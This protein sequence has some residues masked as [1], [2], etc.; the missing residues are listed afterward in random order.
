MKRSVLRFL[1]ALLLFSGFFL[2]LFA[3]NQ[4]AA[5]AELLAQLHP[6]AP[7][8]LYLLAALLF[9]GLT[10]SAYQLFS[11]PKRPPLPQS[12]S[13]PEMAAWS[14]YMA[15]RLPAHPMHPDASGAVRDQR[16]VK[17]DLKFLEVDALNATKQMATKNFFVGAFAQS[18]S[19]G[20]TTTLANILRLLR[21][22]YDR[23]H[24]SRHPA[25]LAR[26][27]REVY[28]RLPLSDFRKEELPAHIK[29]IIQ[30]SFSNTLSSLLPAGN[31]LTPFFL[32]LFLAGATNT[33]L[34]CLAGII[35]VRLCQANTADE[36][37]EIVQRSMFEASFMLREI[38]KECNPTLSVTISEAVKKAGIE[39]LDTVQPPTAG[40]GLA[41]DIVSHLASSIKSI[42]REN[43]PVEKGNE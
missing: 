7:L 31:L 9:A 34:T 4:L 27:V 1:F 39:S 21:A 38:V 36:R 8:G 15:K 25:E 30:S 2:L 10:L 11:S 13:S 35:A 28:E 43:V 32:N 23:H 17:T 33:Y 6:Y 20:T 40:S 19:Y 16:W 12:D 18:T 42:I 14:A 22:I 29:P 37:D 41:Q 3:L 26:L 5:A 24:E